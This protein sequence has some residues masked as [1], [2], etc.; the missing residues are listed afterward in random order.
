MEIKKIL[1]SRI[2]QIAAA[3]LVFFGAG[4]LV[5]AAVIPR[6]GDVVAGAPL[7]VELTNDARRGFEAVSNMQAAFREISSTILPAVVEIDVVDVVTQTA[8]SFPSPFD[9]FFG[10]PDTLRPQ[11]RQYR[12][13]GLGSGVIV[14]QVGNRV[15][16]LTN[17]HVV[18]GAD[19][20]TVVLT[21]KRRFKATVTGRDERKD[22]ALVSFTASGTFPVAALGDSDT[23]QVGDWV[24]AVGN[25][26]GFSST[27][28]EGII[29]AVGR[30][31]LPG[32]GVSS[33]NDYFQTDAAINQGNSG[34]ALVNI[35]GRVVGINTWIAST[36][37]GSVGLGFAIPINNAKKAIEDFITKGKVSYGWLG[38]S[39]TDLN[40]AAKA[41]LGAA[42][43]GGAFVSDVY[44]NSP[45]AA[46]GVLPGDFIV[47]VDGRDL[48]DMTQLTL[49]VGNLPAGA[50]A[51]FSVVRQ[52]VERTLSVAITERPADND[53]G[54]SELW[55]GLG[56]VKITNDIRARLGLAPSAG[57]LVVSRV[58]RGSPAAAA[59]FLAGDIV[60]TMNGRTAATLR[61]FYAALNDRSHNPVR[62]GI[63]RS[64]ADLTIDLGR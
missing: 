30:H 23:V 64:G 40:D 21:D 56:L 61:E 4:L 12:Q 25:P 63:I 20:I 33:L 52:G 28:T 26:L 51:T 60:K 31:S 3:A 43:R 15:Y 9:F 16:V 35:E 47:K 18:K 62:V 38:I 1:K 42:N 39:G 14:R 7:N 24:M 41:D 54:S 13:E 46:A 6:G 10:S 29:S 19:E 34:G 53:L 48:S 37:G 44:R 32:S 49:T 27:V 22:L 17:N 8:P 45:A 58:D 57:G 55:P 36:S 5:S 2:F 11:T 50:R 59:G